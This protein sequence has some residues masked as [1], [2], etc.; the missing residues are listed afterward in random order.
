GAD[1][2]G[3]PGKGIYFFFAFAA[4]LAGAFFAFAGAAFPL[5]AAFNAAPAENLG[6]F[7]AA[8]LISLPVWGFLPF[9]AFL[10]ETENVPNPMRVTLPPFRMASVI[11][12]VTTARAFAAAALDTLVSAATLSTISAFVIASYLLRYVLVYL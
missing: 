12:P 7:F 3:P 8:I 5:A 6:T 1:P 9:L 2:Q 4:F 10:S 11:E